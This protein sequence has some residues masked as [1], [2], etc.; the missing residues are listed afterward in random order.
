MSTEH[1]LDEAIDHARRYLEARDAPKPWRYRIG[2]VV[3]VL[4]AGALLVGSVQAGRWLAWRGQP[5]ASATCEASVVEIYGLGLARIAEM[6][7]PYRQM[8]AERWTVAAVH[9]LAECAEKV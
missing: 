6:H 4:L 1:D 7:E 2:G 9:L 8:Y 5:P 3:G